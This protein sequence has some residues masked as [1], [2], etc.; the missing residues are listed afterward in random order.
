MIVLQNES[1]CD[2]SF[3]HVFRRVPKTNTFSFPLHYQHAESFRTNPMTQP[4]K[5]WMLGLPSG[6]EGGGTLPASTQP[7]KT[8]TV[9][10]ALHPPALQAWP[11]PEGRLMKDRLGNWNGFLSDHRPVWVGSG[12]CPRLTPPQLLACRCSQ[13]HRLWRLGLCRD[14]MAWLSRSEK[15]RR[16]SLSCHSIALCCLG[17]DSQVLVSQPTTSSGPTDRPSTIPEAVA[18]PTH[19]DLAS[20]RRLNVRRMNIWKKLVLENIVAEQ[21][22]GHVGKGLILW[23]QEFCFKVRSGSCSWMAKSCISS[24][25]VLLS[26]EKCCEREREERGQR[27]QPTNSLSSKL[28]WLTEN[29]KPLYQPVNQPKRQCQRS[30]HQP[31]S[32]QFMSLPTST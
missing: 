28:I 13:W 5:A 24:Q 32:P 22:C 16:F 15:R 11:P 18:C 1:Q 19:W 6:P 30:A 7:P 14:P 8:L 25:E 21:C 17:D 26:A 2:R 3:Q 12:G 29:H 20:K 9:R 4:V 27:D 31:L 10:R 23:D